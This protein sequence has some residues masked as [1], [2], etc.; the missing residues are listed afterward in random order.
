MKRSRFSATLLA[1]FFILLAF[2]GYYWGIANPIINHI[3]K[4][5]DLAGGVH[6]VLHAVDT[7][8]APVTPEAMSTAVEVIRRRVD[9]LGV[10]EPTIQQWGNDRIV[11]D[12]PGAD[13]DRALEVIGRTAKLEF[14]DPDGQVI[15][16]GAQ[17]VRAQA[18]FD[19][20]GEPIVT[21]QFD[22]EGSRRFREATE[23]LIG[24]PISIALDGEILTSPVVNEVI[25]SGEAQ[26]SGGFS[27]LEEAQNIAVA[28][29]SGALPVK[30]EVIENRSV[31]ASLGESSIARSGQAAVYGVVLVVLF[32]LFVYRLPGLMA[33][34]A[35][36]VYV[37]L[38]LGALVALNATLTLP[39]IAGIILSVGMAV[40][41]NIIIFE[42]I[43]EELKMGKTVRSAITS[44]FQN[45]FSAI[46][47]ANVTTL[48]ATAA[49]FYW[50]TGPIRG[51]A[52][53]LSIGVLCSMFTAIVVT[54]FL[55]RHLVDAGIF[56]DPRRLF[57]VKEAA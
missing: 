30:L 37:L 42:R 32:M 35:L 29:S 21:L 51:F 12:L 25:P 13:P 33:N 39:G 57:G 46:L 56:R 52:V 26:I 38:L 47:D 18:A 16:T 48:I 1:G 6:V 36:A 43:R 45:A 40:D 4:G 14:L 31:S 23:R 27:S 2:A 53:T 55:L 11:V 19:A 7:A 20:L 3:T 17:L 24:Q 54:R 22:A 5:L 41:A 8:E 10:A 9:S 15:V 28:L 34:A 50:G 44:G 49:L